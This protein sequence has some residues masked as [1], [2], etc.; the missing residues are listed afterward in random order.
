MG[1]ENMTMTLPVVYY[2]HNSN[3]TANT[4]FQSM[5]RI[6]PYLEES[7]R[8]ATSTGAG[9]YTLIAQFMTPEG[10]PNIN[11]LPPGN[12]K[13]YTYAKIDSTSTGISSLAYNLSAYHTNGTEHQI[14][15]FTGQPLTTS[16]T[17]LIDEYVLL[18][19]YPMDTTDRFIM[20]YYLV[21]TSVP[22]REATIYFDDN[23]RVSKI[24]SPI[25]S[26]GIQGPPGPAGTA[27]NE[28]YAYKPGLP[29]G[30]VITGGTAAN[31][32]LILNGT[33]SATKTSSYVILQLD[34]GRVGIGRTPGGVTLDVIG[35]FRL[36]STVLD[37]TTKNA[38][39]LD[40]HYNNSEESIAMFFTAASNP[41]SY[42]NVG[43]GSTVYNAATHIIFYTSPTSTTLQGIERMR[44]SPNGNLSVGGTT[45]T[46]LID[47]YSDIRIRGL[48]AGT[49]YA[50]S[51]GVLYTT[52][53]AK[54]KSNI[55]YL[56]DDGSAIS[57]TKALKPASYTLNSD[58][59]TK[60]GFIAGDVKLIIP[61]AVATKQD[62]YY[63]NVIT[64]KG[65]T[66]EEDEYE[67]VFVPTGTTTDTFDDR[68]I[69]ANLVQALKEEDAKNTALEARVAALEKKLG[70]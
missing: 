18:N 20:R 64:K 67:S 70:V 25:T 17:R 13:W 40:G 69:I 31:D 65:K 59:Q 42:L 11:A 9:T 43:G 52:S 35:S 2:L 50:D 44:I 12:R 61:E 26:Q 32:D 60:I 39:Y 66:S 24:E 38:Y 37:M 27:I 15:S 45:G 51:N 57:K 19:A 33:S 53:D 28:S 34:G 46:A 8:S 55:K 10:D 5:S 68:A 16:V 47:D 54:V 14:Y 4:S 58:G 36:Q 7:N 63:K 1:P 62:G 6:Y 56:S 22:A 49:V 23:S 3:E 21:T 48:G 29:G 41:Y 30:Q